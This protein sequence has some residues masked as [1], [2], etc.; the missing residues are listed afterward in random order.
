[1]RIILFTTILFTFM[2]ADAQINA[3]DPKDNEFHLFDA[4]FS[5]GANFSQVDGDYYAGFNKLGITAGPII[6]I[7][8]N[9]NWSASLELLYSQKGAKSKP[10]PN[11][12]NTY[13]FVL[14]YAEVPVLINYNDKNR[15]LF[16]AGLAY[17]RNIKAFEEVNGID[18]NGG[19]V[20]KSDELSY[21][22]GGTFLIGE[23]KHWGANFRYEGSITKVGPS[24]NPKVVGL[25]NRLIA[26]RGIY[27]F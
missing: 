7:N 11:N 3:G 14:D 8:F 21:V 10:D 13:L 15:L 12:V 23:M 5:V 22:L 24:P 18:T 26:V 27:Y 1:M 19:E 4:G 25:V 16:Q 2:V 9:P 6:H 20:I 17:G